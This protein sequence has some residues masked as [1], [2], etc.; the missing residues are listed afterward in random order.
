MRSGLFLRHGGT[1][2][3][4]IRGTVGSFLVKISAAGVAFAVEVI[5]A[6]ALGA[7]QFGM[8]VYA[9]TWTLV[10]ALVARLGLDN[11]SVR[12]VSVY[13]ARQEWGLLRG[14]RRRSWRLVLAAAVVL[15]AVQAAVAWLLRAPLGL[16]Q[17]RVFWVACLLLPVVALN[18]VRQGT[19]RGLK[20]VVEADL[21]ENVLR[22]LLLALAV[23]VLYLGLDR[24]LAAAQAMALH[25]LA[26]AAALVVGSFW[27]FRTFP[28]AARAAAPSY[29]TGLWIRVA[30]P[31]LAIAGMHLLLGQIDILMIGALL[32]P[33]SAGLYAA[34]SRVAL[35]VGLAL[36]AVNSI[37]GPMVADFHAT[38]RHRQLQ[39]AVTRVAR[40]VL[41]FAV[42]A[43]ALLVA[44]GT[45]LLRLFG[46]EFTVA[47]NPLYVLVAGQLV[48]A[49]VGSVGLLMTMTGAQNRAAAIIGVAT[50]L[51][52]VL[53]AV[54]IP[55][56]GLL[57]AAA[58]TAASTAAWNLVMLVHV[59][60]HLGINP[61]AF[62]RG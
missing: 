26:A 20:R 48:N 36:Q 24:P 58:A 61:T 52:I 4:L 56:F 46:P 23:L 6:R 28:P 30:L 60:R 11:G 10:L 3:T 25:A 16:D 47:L 43:A 38:G 27:L 5:L 50:V 44:L 32:G 18:G 2:A 62:A 40:G 55:A 34:A 17:V 53:N 29:D 14:F 13:N 35:V 45:P 51:N 57:G 42:I 8:Y 31:L 54:L 9:L 33:T 12:F 19:L 37:L 49:L 22:P 1:T 15:G 39:Q 41:V 7:A 21:P 59:R